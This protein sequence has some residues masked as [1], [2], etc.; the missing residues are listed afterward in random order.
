M[1]WISKLRLKI[2][3]TEGNI[4]D[5]VLVDL[6]VST[7]L[8]R[9]LDVRSFTSSTELAGVPSV[10]PRAAVEA[11]LMSCDLSARVDSGGG[12][13]SHRTWVDCMILGYCMMFVWMS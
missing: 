13:I 1:S 2:A 8:G 9:S 4:V 11:L 5:E 7:W 10:T 3:G 12:I 6:S